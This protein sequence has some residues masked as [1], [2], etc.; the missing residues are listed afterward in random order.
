MKKIIIINGPNLNLLGKREPQ[1][2]GSLTFSEF[3]ETI[4][5]KYPQ[6]NLEYYQSNIEGEIIDKLQE[7]GYSHYGIIL[8]AAA[9]T[10]TSVGIGD[11]VAA[12]ETAVVEVHISN[13]FERDEYRHK[14]Y[15]APY[16]K[17]VIVGFGLQSYELALQSFLISS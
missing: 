2:Y 11:A 3:F 5:A 10:H 7:V 6:V 17:G 1:I 14:S 16:A 4:K 12:I 13:T 8:N 15:V 9:Y